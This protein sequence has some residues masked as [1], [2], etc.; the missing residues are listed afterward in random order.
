MPIFDYIVQKPNVKFDLGS[1]AVA[2]RHGARLHGDHVESWGP[3]VADRLVSQG[4]LAQ[5]PHQPDAEFFGPKDPIQF[6]KAPEFDIDVAFAKY[7]ASLAHRGDSSPAQAEPVVADE[8]EAEP[9]GEDVAYPRHT[10]FGRYELSDGSVVQ[11]K[12][13]AV[14]AQAE[15]EVDDEAAGA[16]A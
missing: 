13:A 14:K 7:E 12:D 11:G 1:G 10:G 16:D 6:D 9:D 8:D 15:L 5:V 4:V 3:N 2:V